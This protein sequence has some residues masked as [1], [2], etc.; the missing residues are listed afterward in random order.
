MVSNGFS[1]LVFHPGEILLASIPTSKILWADVCFDH[2]VELLVFIKCIH[3]YI[4]TGI[5]I[6][7]ILCRLSVS[8]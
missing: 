7:P 1:Q 2:F 3:L 6:C 8:Y 4:I 5:F